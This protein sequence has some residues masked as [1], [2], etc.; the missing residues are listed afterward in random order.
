MPMLAARLHALKNRLASLAQHPLALPA[1]FAV[2]LVE[3][4][5]VP[6]P[7]DLLLIPL[8]LARPGR[9]FISASVCIAG[10]VTGAMIGYVIGATLFEDIGERLIALL[11]VTRAFDHVLLLYREN[12]LGTLLVA[13][14]TSIPFSVFTIAAGFHRTLGPLTL[15]GGAVMGRALRFYLL[16]AVLSLGG[17][18]IRRAIERHLP[19]LSI[20]LLLLMVAGFFLLRYLS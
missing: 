20:V 14:F 15:L 5:T 10:S 1:L 19:A 18:P 16:A 3:A 11:G 9:A 4:S 13:G 12:A 7:P 8:V 2:A 17:P 6:V